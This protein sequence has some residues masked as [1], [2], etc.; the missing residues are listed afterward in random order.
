MHSVCATVE[1]AHRYVMKFIIS[2]SFSLSLSHC[3]VGN[4]WGIDPDTGR[5]CT[6]C[7]YQEE[8]YG[9]ADISIGHGNEPPIPSEAPTTTFRPS[10]TTRRPKSTTRQ[11]RPTTHQ[12]TTVR[13]T[14]GTTPPVG[15]VCK[16]VG[17]WEHQ[18][19]MHEWCQKNCAVGRCP[20]DMCICTKESVNEVK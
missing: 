19:G 15:A 11:A 20:P 10:H 3:F 14:R 1:V 12:P 9:C 8:F 7:G 4:T 17:K 5:G 16:P 6:G 18:P 2:K 13:P